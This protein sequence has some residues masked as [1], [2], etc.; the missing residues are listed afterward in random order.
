MKGDPF[1]LR[2]SG[3][4]DDA[5]GTLG[6]RGLGGL[7]ATLKQFDFE[8]SPLVPKPFALIFHVPVLFLPDCARGSRVVLPSGVKVILNLVPVRAVAVKGWPLK[9]VA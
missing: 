4:P 8:C 6:S 3:C 2:S 7:T 1:S 5:T 9:N